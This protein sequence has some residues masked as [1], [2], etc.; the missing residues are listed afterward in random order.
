VVQDES[1]MEMYEGSKRLAESI[2]SEELAGSAVVSFG[3]DDESNHF[4]QRVYRLRATAPKLE[5][6]LKF[7][8]GGAE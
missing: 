5:L 4:Y 6:P 7:P 3:R 2:F 1:V 8:G